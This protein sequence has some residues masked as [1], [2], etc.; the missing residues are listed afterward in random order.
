MSKKDQKNKELAKAAA[1]ADGGRGLPGAVAGALLAPLVG[2]PKNIG[3]AL[4]DLRSI[5]EAVQVLP[6]VLKSLE[7]IEKHVTSLDE[8]VIIMR[9][10]VETLETRVGDLGGN[11]DR[12][13]TNMDH[14]G[15]GIKDVG[16]RVD[17]LEP[18]LIEMKASLQPLKRVTG[19]I[20]RA[21][22]AA[23]NASQDGTA[24]D[25][26]ASKDGKAGD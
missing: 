9:R 15:D 20:G 7:R 18:H 19:R 25:E 10:G 8:E 12:L 3:G 2:A 6:R 1:E 5:A 11:I 24:R 17:Q 4:E 22:S 14:L 21:N 26:V 13:G 16:V 23:R